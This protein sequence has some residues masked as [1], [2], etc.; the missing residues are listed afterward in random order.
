MFTYKTL[1]PFPSRA[2][3]VYAMV[4]IFVILGACLWFVFYYVF[5]IIQ[6]VAEGL[7]VSMGTNGT[8]WDGVDTFFQNY[9][10]YALVIGLFIML[11]AAIV[12]SQRRGTQV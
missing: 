10:E 9:A 12:Y 5:W 11:V 8:E 6:P 1:N 3:Y 7:T 4:I 2:L